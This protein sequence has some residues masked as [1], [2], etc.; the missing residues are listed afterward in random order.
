M[1]HGRPRVA[2]VEQ[3]VVFSADLY[4]FHVSIM[5]I[6]QTAFL[7]HI[8]IKTKL[9]P[10]N[11]GI[12]KAPAD[13]RFDP[14]QASQ[15]G[16]PFGTDRKRSFFE[17]DQSRLICLPPVLALESVVALRSLPPHFLLLLRALI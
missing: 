13:T 11:S 17:T 12:I 1:T 4:S 3:A 6:L 9:L 16:Q 8:F 14:T 5:D 7:H 2:G 10:R 15:E